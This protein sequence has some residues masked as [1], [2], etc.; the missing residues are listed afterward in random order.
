MAIRLILSGRMAGKTESE[1]RITFAT[2]L[3][4]ERGDGI[5]CVCVRACVLV[6]VTE[7]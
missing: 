5:S 2:T 3:N 1:R 6:C 4:M 7:G